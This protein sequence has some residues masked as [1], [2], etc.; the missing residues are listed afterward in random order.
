MLQDNGAQRRVVLMPLKTHIAQKGEP[1]E[2]PMVVSE[3]GYSYIV[4]M[5]P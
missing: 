4:R 1:S 3:Q 2:R 5:L